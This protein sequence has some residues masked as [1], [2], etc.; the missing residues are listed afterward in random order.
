MRNFKFILSIL[1][2]LASI[3]VGG[4]VIMAE[5]VVT[6]L[7]GGGASLTEGTGKAPEG[8]FSKGEG[9]TASPD[10][11]M[12]DV[13]ERVTKIS[14]MRTPIDQISRKSGRA[15]KCD[16]LEVKY[17]SVGN[18][19]IKGEVNT[20]IAASDSKDRFA[21]DLVDSSMLDIQDTARFIG[22]SGYKEDG[23]T[24]DTGVDFVVL[25]IGIDSDGYRVCQPV[26]GPTKGYPKIDKGTTVIRM[27]RA[28]AEFDVQT[29]VF[30]NVPTPDTQY[31]QKFMMQVEEST[32]AAMNKKEVDWGFSDLERDGI[33][34]LKIGMEGSFMFGSKRKFKHLINKQL[35]YTTGGIYWMAG[36]N[37]TL[38]EWIMTDPGDNSDPDNPVA[39]TY[40][41][42]FTDDHLVDLS[43]DLFTGPGA[44]NRRKVGLAGKNALAALSKIK[45]DTKSHD[46]PK[47]D[48]WDLTFS[49]FRTE[50]GELLVMYCEMMDLQGKEDEVLVLDPEYMTKRYFKGWS[51]EEYD[52]KKLAIRDTNAVVLT[53]E[54]CIYLTNPNAHAIL[55]LASDPSE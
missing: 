12:A 4:G 40:E 26:N 41:F 46:R 16:S 29:S 1:M 44:G 47:V 23:S 13:D 9:E 28:G 25:V 32:W 34:T 15:T 45:S 2:A 35:V 31:C 8:V 49:S 20:A 6:P 38:G 30:S 43:K 22:V 54:S 48:V 10:L 18:R 11:F 21:L 7:D 3:F 33:E 5:T 50:F 17:Y 27:G 55:T 53:E 39:P 36:K 37:L 42:S 52:M 24:V 19:P 14:Q 51:R